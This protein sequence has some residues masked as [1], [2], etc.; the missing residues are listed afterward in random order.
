V[1]VDKFIQKPEAGK[2]EESLVD[3]AV[4]GFLIKGGITKM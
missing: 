3:P 1:Q 2:P 4:D